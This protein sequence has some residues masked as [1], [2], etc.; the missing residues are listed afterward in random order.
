MAHIGL[1]P[2]TA[3]LGPGYKIRSNRDALLADA[4][5]AQEAGAYAVVLEMVDQQIAA[6]ITQML[7]IPTIGIG[8]GRSCDGQVLVMHDLLGLFENAPSFAKQYT[9]LRGQTIAAL[10]AFAKEVREKSFPA[11]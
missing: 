4:K 7:R 2:Q 6:E 9:D 10:Q 5:A 3:G 8:S 11:D 1:L